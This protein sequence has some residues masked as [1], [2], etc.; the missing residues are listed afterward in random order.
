MQESII[1]YGDGTADIVKKSMISGKFNM[2]TMQLTKEQFDKWYIHRELIQIALPHL[3]D[4]EREF[5]KT[6]ITSE[7]WDATFKEEN[8]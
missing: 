2:L 6:G 5:L 8:D 4:N 7:E 3:S 1:F